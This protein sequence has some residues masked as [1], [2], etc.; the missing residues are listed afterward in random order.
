M[1]HKQQMSYGDSAMAWRLIP[2]TG[3]SRAF[4]AVYLPDE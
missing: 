4:L 3:G 2:H 1:T